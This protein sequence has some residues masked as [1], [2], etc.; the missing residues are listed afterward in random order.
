V[1]T[2]GSFNPPGA[3]ECAYEPEMT[4][5]AALALR[6]AGQLDPNCVVVI[7]DGPVI[8]TPGNTSPTMIELNPVTPTDLG[9]LAR[10]HTNFDNVAY[11]GN[12][13]IDAGVAGSINELIDHWNNRI[14]DEDDDAP[15]VHTQFPYHLSGV[16]Q[17]D[18]VVNDCVL[19]GWDTAGGTRNDNDIRN[20]TVNL[21]GKTAGSFDRNT[22]DGGFLNALVATS[23]IVGNQLTGAQVDHQG[24]GAGSFS[25]QNNVMLN[26]VF[27]VDAAS[28]SQVTA[29][30]N[31]SGGTAGAYRVNIE[32]RTGGLVIV[33]GNRMFNAGAAVSEL[34][35]KGSGA[36][37]V[38]VTA[39]E[40]TA[41][42][43]DLDGVG[44]VIITGSS[45]GRTI[46]TKD[47]ASTGPLLIQ[48]SNMGQF[49]IT[50][51]STNGA[52]ANNFTNVSING[53]FA[54]LAGP[55]A[56]PGRND[57]NSVQANTANWIVDD[58]ATAGINLT[59][60]YYD[61]G[62]VRQNRTAGTGSTNL[63]NCELIGAS[64]IVT[65][66]GTTDPTVAIGF[67]R[68]RFVDSTVSMGN[69]GVK[70][71]PGTVVQQ[72]DMLGSTLDLTGLAGASLVDRGR[73]TGST[74]NN[75]GFSCDVFEMLGATKTLTA[76]NASVQADPS[77]DNFV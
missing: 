49:T 9:R 63:F 73:M 8:G 1:S 71:A 34:L 67:N 44:S 27:V 72:V 33:S 41:T 39:N 69:I 15:T 20:A 56:A 46:V 70:A 68:C 50:M 25:F 21:T 47:P 10:I 19:I 37:S 55:V 48:Q 62:R 59:G 65:D 6:A 42:D 12:Y 11:I 43:L 13:N 5:A 26:G 2:S 51:G 32:G 45:L 18:N 38:S 77:F 64:T 60:G 4:R 40:L 23:F 53:G 54:T 58:T 14:S 30:N 52:A 57:F 7:T 16:N 61:G 76:N 28:T 3:P 36:G 24:A 31:V 22:I 35:I 74:L 17:R 66:N 29:N 75:A